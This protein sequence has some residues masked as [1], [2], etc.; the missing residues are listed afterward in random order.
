MK[1]RRWEDAEPDLVGVID[2]VKRLVRRARRR[3]LLVVLTTLIMA[4]LLT[5]REYRKQR[6]YPATVLLSATEAEDPEL[7]SVNNG[8]RLQDY[9]WYAVFT[10]ANLLALADKH[11]FRPDLM[12]KNPRQLLESF[13]DDLDVDV[14]KNEFAH[15]RFPGSPPRSAR[16]AIEMKMPDPEAAVAITRDLGDLVI[17][18]DAENRKERYDMA[19]EVAMGAVSVADSEVLRLRRELDRAESEYA[20]ASSARLGELRVTI[21][22][23]DRAIVAAEARLREAD[24]DRRHLELGSN[25]DTGNM[26]LRWERVDW[27]VA[28]PR[29]NQH[30]VL[31]RT[32]LLGFLGLLPLVALFVGAFDPRVYDDRD[33]SR[34]GLRPLGLVRRADIGKGS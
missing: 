14:F 3:K 22:K 13:R 5:L 15:E 31:V 10:D 4:G 20:T 9:V 16:V 6:T 32:G 29:V 12:K 19:R 24:Q 1:R 11:R 34:L 18:R 2:E 17:E 23:L 30:V 7:A 21:E 28:K 8:T 27:G 26:T 25:A 33:V